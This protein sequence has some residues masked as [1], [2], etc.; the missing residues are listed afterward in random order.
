MAWS[1]AQRLFYVS[2]DG[3]IFKMTK[4]GNCTFLAR[5]AFTNAAVLGNQGDSKA[6]AFVTVGGVTKLWVGH[7]DAGGS[8]TNGYIMEV[9]PVTGAN[10]G[11][12]AL[13]YPPGGVDPVGGE[14][15][16]A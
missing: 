6:I 10:L 11:E 14:H 2:S 9:D 12:L 16:V 13:H 1:T 4:D 15:L 3:G 7:K 8:D 5:P